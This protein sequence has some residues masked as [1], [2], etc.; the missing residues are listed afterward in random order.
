MT[1]NILL[2]CT[3]NICRSPIAQEL[4]RARLVE[5][6][7][8]GITSAGFLRAGMPAHPHAIRV[9]KERGLDLTAHSSQKVG[10]AIENLP[11]LVLVMER[12]HRNALLDLD[13]RL[14]ERTFTIREFARLSE[15]EGPR[16]EA[17]DLAGYLRRVG[18]GRSTLPAPREKSEDIADP[19]GQRRAAFEKCARELDGELAR[20]AQALHP[21]AGQRSLAT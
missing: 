9:M 20:I 8:S 19:I 10:S 16:Q 7:R 5:D 3:A 12:Q 6:L 15:I 2:V 18:A 1:E 17:E 13:S 21:A 11:D 4:L 14:R